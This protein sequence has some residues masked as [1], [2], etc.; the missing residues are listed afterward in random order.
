MTLLA[1]YTPTYKRPTLLEKCKRSVEQ[2]TCGCQ[3]III[4]DEVGIGIGGMY[5]DIQNHVDEV[6]AEYVLVL[7]DDNCLYDEEVVEELGQFI[8]EHD[9]PD[10]V[11]WRGNLGWGYV[12]GPA[13]W[14][15]KPI[16]GQ[17]DLSNFIVESS[18]W[19]RHANDWPDDYCGDFYFADALYRAGHR[20]E[21]FDRLG[22]YA[23]KISKGEPE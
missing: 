7:S 3:H 8:A 6:D 2:Q 11:V 13:C 15:Q 16:I 19:K 18:I 14:K 17:I 21:W 1:I 22:Y 20:F 10:V 9:R 12:P 23:M 4:P 5:R